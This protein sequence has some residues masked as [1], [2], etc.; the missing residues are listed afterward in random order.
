MSELTAL[1]YVADTGVEN[2]STPVFATV[3]VCARTYIR[4]YARACGLVCAQAVS[5]S[6]VDRAQS[7]ERKKTKT[8]TRN[9]ARREYEREY[10]QRSFI[11][12][13]EQERCVFFFSCKTKHTI[14]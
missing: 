2:R 12:D 13:I 4:M 9:D 1:S 5:E 3:H 14:R 11:A 10:S 7:A 6:P 8:K